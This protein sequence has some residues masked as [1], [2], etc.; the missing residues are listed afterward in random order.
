MGIMVLIHG[1]FP[2]PSCWSPSGQDPGV[3]Q[4]QWRPAL[5][6]SLARLDR[7]TSRDWPHT[8]RRDLITPPPQIALLRMPTPY[9]ESLHIPQSSSELQSHWYKHFIETT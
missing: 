3:V 9:S 6:A 8:G 7:V 1:K 4:R 5:L 2:V